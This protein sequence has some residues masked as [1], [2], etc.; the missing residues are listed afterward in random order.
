MPRRLPDSSPE[1]HRCAEDSE[2]LRYN[3][4]TQVV[5]DLMI[6]TPFEEARDFPTLT[7]QAFHERFGESIHDVLNIQNWSEGQDLWLLYERL[8][9]EVAEAVATEGEIQRAIRADLFPQ[10][11]RTKVPHAGVYRA[12]P[13]DLELVHRGLLFNGAVEACEA[14]LNT[15]DTLPVTVTQIG[16]SLVRYRG[17]E[18]TW[19]Q[20]LIR[21]DLRAR[22]DNLMDKVFDLLDQRQRRGG[23]GRD[24]ERDQFNQLVRRGLVSYA[25][26]ATLLHRV[27]TVWRVGHGVPAPLELLTGSGLPDLLA[28]SIDVLDGLLCGHK[29]FLFV[30]RTPAE[31][32]W[33][34]I[35]EALRPLE[36][37]I[38][39]TTL[40]SMRRMVSRRR[41]FGAVQTRALEF[42]EAAGRDVLIG[43]YRASALSPVYLFYAH[44]EH[45]H[46]AALIAIAD[47]VLQEHRGFP[48]LLDLA[49]LACRSALGIESLSPQV[50]MALN[51]SDAPLRYQRG[52]P[53][54][55][56]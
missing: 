9:R 56:P 26:R 32:E 35:G 12:E 6:T 34:T 39:D 43:L 50:E 28:A 54:A 49:D 47:S 55:H 20:R 52:S 31:R 37:M 1:N 8:R 24:N 13:R 48:L 36:Y 41:A 5:S 25:Q 44:H 19:A 17:S 3:R 15:Y 23:I 22:Y 7:A 30:P 10:I 11:A 16:L 14:A 29:R 40:E 33:L 21:H 38:V 4:D 42:V 18:N 2:I 51:E 46:E 53:N 45:V 27:E